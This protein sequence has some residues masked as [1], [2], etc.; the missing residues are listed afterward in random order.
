MNSAKYDSNYEFIEL[1]RTFHELLQG[2][3]ENEVDIDLALSFGERL[4]WT[5]LLE[6][7]RLII[8]SEAGTGKTAEIRNAAL[9]LKDE[10][11]PAFFIRLEDVPQN[12]EDAFEVGTYEDFEKWLASYEEGWLFLD[13]VDEARLRSPGDF[14]LAIRKLSNRIK[15]AK[16]R[17]HITI[18]SR[19]TAWRPKT[20]LD[21]CATRF[22]YANKNTPKQDSSIEDESVHTE[23]ETQNNTQSVFKIVAFDDLT[24]DQI[25]TFVKTRKIEN[26]RAFLDAV[27]RKDAWSFTSRPQDLEEL[28][29]F[30]ID[31]GKI[32]TRLEIINN[33][34]E[35]RL[36]ERDQDRAEANPFS[37]EYA[38]Q[39]ARLLAAAT[40]LVQ[41]PAIGVPDGGENSKGIAIKSILSDWNDKDQSILLSRPIFDEEIYGT[42][43]FHHRSVREYLTAE[44]FAEL[45]KH[46]TSRRNIEML[47]FCN[48]YGLDIIV[49]TL[50]PILSWLAILDDKI[51]ERVIK[52]APEV[53]FEGGDPSQLPLDTRRHIL[54]K[55][56]K[57]IAEGVT[58]RSIYDYAAVQRFANSDLADDV[59]ALLRQYTGNED[60]TVFLLRMVWIGQLEGALPEAMNIALMSEADEYV[61]KAAFRAINA[62]GSDMD[63]ERIRQSF[64]NES[65]VLK[66]EWLSVLLEGVQPSQKILLWLLACLEKIEPKER[67]TV[68][69]LTG[70]VTEFADTIAIDLLPQLVAG[71]NRLLG[72]PP[73]IEPPYCEVSEKFQWL[74]VPACKV[75][76]RLILTRHPAS[77]DHGALLI[78]HQFSTL[79]HYGGNHYLADIKTE[80]TKL[81]PAWQKLN[82]TLFWFEIQKTRKAVYN[83]PGE[84][85]TE[86]WQA[87]IFGSFW[88]FEEND[89]EYVA[90][91]VSH[92]KFLDDKL[93]ALSLA[94]DLYKN[95][96]RPK[97]WRVKLKELVAGNDELSK[98]LGTYLKPPAQSPHERRR[99]QQHTRSK[100][101][102]EAY[103]KKQAKYHTNWKKYL[104]DNLDEIKAE[105]NENPGTVTSPL[106]YLFERTRDIKHTSSRW[107]D[108]NW[109]TLISE[110]GEEIARFYRDGTVSFWRH[111][112]PTLRS[113]G[114]PLN[115]TT[116]ATIIGLTG[117]EIE[118][119][120]IEDWSQ[121]LS[122]VEVELAC[123]YASFELNGFPVWFPKLFATHP[124]IVSDFI[125]REIRY[126]L[127]IETSDAD[128]HH[129]ISDMSYSGQ[130]AW[131]QLAPDIFEILSKEP[132]NLSNLDDLLCIIQGAETILDDCIEKLAARKC[133]SLKSSEHVARWFA[134]WTGVAPSAAIVALKNQL[135]EITTPEKQT[136]FAMIFITN[137]LG[138][139]R[140]NGLSIRQSFKMPE[141]L[142]SLYLLMYK[143]IRSEEDI[144][145]VGTGA[146]SPGLRDNAQDARSDLLNLLNQIPGKESFLAL[147]D[148][149]RLHP[150]KNVRPWI[151]LQAKAKAEKD[152]NIEPWFLRQVRE[153]DNEMERTP[154]NHKELAELAVLRLLDLKDDLE[155]GDSSVA[156]ILQKVDLEIEIR[157]YIGKELQEKAFGRYSIPQEEELADAKKPD[158]RFHGVAFDCQVPVELKLADNWTGPK[159]FERL[160]NQ[161]CGNYLRDNRSNHGIFLLVYRGN[162]H[163]WTLPGNGNHVKFEELTATLQ[164]HWLQISPKFPNVDDITVIGI[165]LTK[166]SN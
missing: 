149:A 107:T 6:E 138:G 93:V 44:W 30:W 134:V 64:L 129:I 135:A 87:S 92:Q 88:Q 2:G 108:Y 86:F 133:R 43:R 121:C 16:D 19:T 61:R 56:C 123:R 23:T 95:A 1:N 161:L 34:I 136:L 69:H 68:D 144:N 156:G 104:N 70:T 148:I 46:E 102:D 60:L 105:L 26:S 81:V 39:G 79:R 21:Y 3:S 143:Y 8:L 131:D 141:Y 103:R 126:E 125:M 82:R 106:R 33:S 37:M 91:E 54:H 35:R 57:Q 22:P 15:T 58:G 117:L 151:L 10:E 66:R 100:R 130:W 65:P 140:G 36:A 17:T 53:I 67:Y 84:Q 94:F 119:H 13:S 157:K 25:K 159:L 78:M 112:K 99:K 62:I 74:M 18:T 145:R 89:F 122:N 45:L 110:Y 75:V 120:E 38:R 147:E 96:D 163:Y 109:K 40:T 162:K 158:L 71:F 32:G 49:P 41:N 114:A 47:F 150:E 137:L 160:E 128:T 28:I 27:D 77:L 52:V 85:L 146:Y 14:K 31:K 76:E 72:L 139:R 63:C 50:R 155:H 101:R 111:R 24:S 29:E 164:K 153:F 48:K 97:K 115:Q 116:Y 154:T 42:V 124:E 132:K 12:F 20:D 113:E 7:Y 55:V 165:D 59:L 118:S 90:G 9:K 98:R 5:N 127:S 152:G 51:R 73:M 4:N 142:K 166:R 11:K 83:K 80:F